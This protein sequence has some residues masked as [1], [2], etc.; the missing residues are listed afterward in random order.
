[1][2]GALVWDQ[3]EFLNDVLSVIA[4]LHSNHGQ[5][6]DA[7]PVR[8]VIIGHSIGGL[9]ARAAFLLPSYV[10]GSI[11]TLLTLGTPHSSPRIIIDN[12]MADVYHKVN[13]LWR[14]A[15]AKRYRRRSPTTDG[16]DSSNETQSRVMPTIGSTLRDVVLVSLAG[17]Y[18]TIFDCEH[19]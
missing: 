16:T 3:A 6:S 11:S 13:T 2:S 17:A 19:R 5:S 7:I 15:A 14:V 1:M 10:P 18:F 12:A 4:R 9:V 8:P